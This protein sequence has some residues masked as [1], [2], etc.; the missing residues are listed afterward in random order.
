M[1]CAG[2]NVD[3]ETVIFIKDYIMS[4]YHFLPLNNKQ[5]PQSFVSW[6]DVFSVEELERIKQIGDSL[7]S[8]KATIGGVAE[9]EEF[10]D[11]RESKTSWLSYNDDTRWIYDRLAWIGR[12]INE[13]FYKFDLYGFVE[14]M[15]YTIY[16]GE[17]NG[18]Y[19]WHIDM[20]ANT[21][22]ARK[23]TLVLQLSD[24]EDY[25]GGELQVYTK[26][27]PESVDKQLGRIVAFPS[28]T[29]HRVT[30]VTS[31]IRKT[32]VVWIGGESF[33]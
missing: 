2:T 30:P 12:R 21:E 4:L 7:P 1:V 23:L 25:E 26:S 17:E 3:Y 29:L 28:W 14:D 32:L 15:Q 10:S 31:G 6:N 13:D 8:S 18:H 9:E 24:P 11:I 27:E 20:A 22:V 5:L 16:N 33:K 19:T